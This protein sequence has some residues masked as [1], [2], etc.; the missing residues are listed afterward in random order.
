[1]AKEKK[2]CVFS[3]DEADSIVQRDGGIVNSSAGN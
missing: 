1:M 2:G 3:L